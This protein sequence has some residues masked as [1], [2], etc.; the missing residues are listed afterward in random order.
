M[1]IQAL[2]PGLQIFQVPSLQSMFIDKSG[3][4]QY[5]LTA[6]YADAEDD[7]MCIIHSSGT[8]GRSSVRLGNIADGPGNLSES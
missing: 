3:L 1:E 4:R 7:I 2:C 6:T 5:P 8:T